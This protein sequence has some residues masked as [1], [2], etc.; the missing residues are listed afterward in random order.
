MGQA[1]A[2]GP[3]RARPPPA[4]PARWRGRSLPSGPRYI[5]G[6]ADARGRLAEVDR[7]DLA[8]ARPGRRRGS[9]RRRGCPP[10]GGVTAS[11][12]AV[13]TAASTALPPCR[14]TSRPTSAAWPSWADDH[15]PRE[16]PRPRVDGVAPTASA[17]PRARPRPAA[18]D[19]CVRTDS[20]LDGRL[21]AEPHASAGARP[22]S[23]L[24]RENS[25]GGRD[26]VG[27]EPIS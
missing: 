3:S 27:G 16:G 18:S 8:A 25:Q 24:C 2:R 20:A 6:S 4:A 13:A 19:R 26:R 23:R 9:R 5:R 12:K 17:R 21:R 11:A 22:A 1:Q 15:V 10:P 7:D 14:R